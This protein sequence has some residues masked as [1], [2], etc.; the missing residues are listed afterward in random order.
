MKLRERFAE[1]Q[2]LALDLWNGSNDA[3]IQIYADT[4]KTLSEFTRRLEVCKLIV[5]FRLAGTKNAEDKIR[6]LFAARLR[7]CDGEEEVD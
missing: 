2:E 6:E 4:S 1:D 3:L 7:E 5:S